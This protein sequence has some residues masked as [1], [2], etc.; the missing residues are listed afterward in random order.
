MTDML[1]QSTL[2]VRMHMCLFC[3]CPELAGACI[4]IVE[5]FSVLMHLLT[6]AEP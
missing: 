3:C 1:W 6:A 2:L 5:S 4:C